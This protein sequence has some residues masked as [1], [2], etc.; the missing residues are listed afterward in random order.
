M[1]KQDKDIAYQNKDVG[2]KSFADRLRGNT[3]GVVGLNDMEVVDVLPT[4]LPAIE[5][6]E[7]R[8][9][10]LFRLSTGEYAI[11][12]Y[13]SK[14]SEENMI[15]YLG[16]VA[17][18][19]KRLYNNYGEVKPLKMIVIYT[20]DVEKGSTKPLLVMG[21]VTIRV[22]ESFLIGMD[23]KEIKDTLCSKLDRNEPLTNEDIMRLAIYPLTYKGKKAKQKAVTEAIDIAERIPDERMLLDAMK[24]I[25]VFSDIVISKKDA[26][27]IKRRF[28][29][30]QVERMYEEEKEQAVEAA[31]KATEK[32][33]K[34]KA[35]DNMKEVAMNL[36]RM[37]DAVD[38]VIQ[39]TGLSRRTVQA[40]AAKI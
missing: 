14:Y 39:C 10:N 6:N 13:E 2:M 16:Y 25:L 8:L 26:Q 31:V 23:P 22:T 33:A 15:K 28:T 36:L 29:M 37:G 4:N 34:K 24:F 18:V 32:A 20:A 17:R 38:K 19:S 1:G 5:A 35:A 27:R 12:D 9:D 3:L 7:L 30:T 11:I 40:L 21:D